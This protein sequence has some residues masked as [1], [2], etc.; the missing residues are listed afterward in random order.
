MEPTSLSIQ[1][2][3]R[4]SHD[5][6][7]QGHWWPLAGL[8]LIF[9][10]SAMRK[11]AVGKMGRVGAWLATDHGAILLAFVNAAIG[12]TSVALLGGATPTK[13]TLVGALSAGAS[14]VVAFPLVQKFF[15]SAFGIELGLTDAG[16]NLSGSKML[17][18]RHRLDTS[19]SGKQRV[20]AISS[21]PIP[22]ST[23]TPPSGTPVSKEKGF[24]N[25]ILMLIILISG[26][27]V[28]A[29]AFAGCSGCQLQAPTAAQWKTAGIDAGKCVVPA[30]VD[31]AGDALIALLNQAAGQSVDFKTVGIDIA[32][33]YGGA[34]A[35]C[36]AGKLWLDLGGPNLLKMKGQPTK[37]LVMA[38][39][40]V[41][42][43]SEWAP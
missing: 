23:P 13:A 20:A 27:C 12:G 42:H 43:T 14:A 40:L 31:A 5:A 39:W 26:I 7:A 1:Q 6:V 8:A 4:I 21:P 10:V 28:F 38:D 3:F 16:A 25:H 9:V 24:S 29:A 15:R 33:Q 37:A 11:L 19:V 32:K 2:V 18:S 30:V 34:A 17:G 41:H 22:F 35:I 36:A